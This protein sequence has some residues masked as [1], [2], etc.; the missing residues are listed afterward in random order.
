MSTLSTPSIPNWVVVTAEDDE[1]ARA[2]WSRAAQETGAAQPRHVAWSAVVASEAD[3]QPGEVIFAERLYPN[4]TG[5][6]V[7]GHRAR[8]ADLQAALELLDV[9][10]TKAGATLA[11]DVEQTLLALDRTKCDTFLRHSGVPLLELSD[12][13]AVG[14]NILRPRFAGSDEWT[15]DGWR[16]QLIRHRTRTGFEVWRDPGQGDG[17]KRELA[18]VAD[19]LAGDGLHAVAT[20]HRVHLLNDFY[21]FRFAVVDGKATHAAGVK[22]E[23]EALREW[24]GGKR[25]EIDAFVERF[26]A[27]RW[28]RLV[29]LAERTATFFPGIRFLGVDLIMDNEESEYVFDVD[30]FGASLPGLVVGLADAQGEPES[31]REPAR[32]SVRASVLRSLSEL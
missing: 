31:V 29:A 9:A 13:S 2:A 3:F 32:E 30:P 11:A 5:N 16:T 28:A 22:R 15:I 20:Q 23:G 6:P 21:D 18:R 1:P 27:E 10:A 7:G 12:V 8:F 17:D 19:L 24:F 25:R 4:T 14:N 26:T